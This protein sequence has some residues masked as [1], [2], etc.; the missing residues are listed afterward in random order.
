[1]AEN[2][3]CG[4]RALPLLHNQH[5]Q[6][7]SAPDLWTFDDQGAALAQLGICFKQELLLFKEFQVQNVAR[8]TLASRINMQ[9]EKLARRKPIFLSRFERLLRLADHLKLIVAEKF[10]Q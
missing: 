4:G 6:Q 3:A 9:P 10:S 7:L 1:M 5:Q 2:G 8:L